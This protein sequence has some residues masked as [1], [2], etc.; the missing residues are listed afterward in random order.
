[1]IAA[2]GWG[3]RDVIEIPAVQKYTFKVCQIMMTLV[4]PFEGKCNADYSVYTKFAIFIIAACGFGLPFSWNEPPT[5]VDGNIT[6]QEA[7]DISSNYTFMR[8]ISP[9]WIW[10][11]PIAKYD[12]RPSDIG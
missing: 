1:M 4:S 7:L 12:L 6:L 10:K 8:Q 5:G 3:P 2:E 9:K 11:L